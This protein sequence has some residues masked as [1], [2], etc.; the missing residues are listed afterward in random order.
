MKNLICGIIMA[1]SFLT[2]IGF[3]GGL[4]VDSLTVGQAVIG[5]LASIA[6][7]CIAGRIGGVIE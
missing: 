6:V 2:A 4:E 7:F 1:V 3:I 5:C